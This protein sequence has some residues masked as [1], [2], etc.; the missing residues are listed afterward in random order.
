MGI[1]K[2]VASGVEAVANAVST[3]AGAIVN[4]DGYDA[5]YSRVDLDDTE[6][7]IHLPGEITDP[8][9]R[10]DITQNDVITED[11][12]GS[13]KRQIVRA[14]KRQSEIESDV[15]NMPLYGVKPGELLN[16]TYEMK[17]S[18]S[19]RPT[20][21]I[22]GI[23]VFNYNCND[24]VYLHLLPKQFRMY[25]QLL[26]NEWFK[27]NNVT[28]EGK[29]T[30]NDVTATM[31]GFI[32]G[33]K[34]TNEISNDVLLTLSKLQTFQPKENI[35]YQFMYPAPSMAKFEKDEG[36]H[37]TRIV[38]QTPFVNPNYICRSD[39]FADNV[40]STNDLCYGTIVILKPNLTEE[41]TGMQFKVT[42]QFNTWNPLN[43]GLS[44]AQTVQII[45]DEEKEEEEGGE[46]SEE[47]GED[48]PGEGP[49][50]QPGTDGAR[51]PA[52]A[53]KNLGRRRRKF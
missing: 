1:I 9:T 50:T 36:G 27:L 8:V 15:L 5:S 52:G 30:T 20:G 35:K 17:L 41:L 18:F 51:P 34:N 2:V 7:D 48:E 21:K 11:S 33:G 23:N 12:I 42:M 13:S 3:V 44:I 47:G 46:S 10:A 45:K 43:S 38:P 49:G 24:H 19:S 16:L 53:E 26:K 29:C 14:I 31:I 25:S 40:D 39:F 6:R 28:I 22:D 4:L 37:I 32:P